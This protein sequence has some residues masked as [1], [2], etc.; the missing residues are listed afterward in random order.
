MERPELIELIVET[1]RDYAATLPDG[2]PESMSAET[3]LFG[4]AGVFD[5]IGLVSVI[6]DLEDQLNDQ[7]GTAITI[8]DERALSAERSPFLT[9]GTLADHVLVLLRSTG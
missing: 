4:A 1:A 7:L 6:A 3:A 5:S 9:V 8:A 2:A